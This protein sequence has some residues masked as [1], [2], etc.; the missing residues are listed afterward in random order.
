[1]MEQPLSLSWVK[2]AMVFALTGGA[3]LVIGNAAQATT[4][5]QAWH[6]GWVR[7]WGVNAVHK[8]DCLTAT[9]SCAGTAPQ[10]RDPNAYVWMPAGVCTE[11]GGT[12]IPG[13][14][15]AAHIKKIMALPAARRAA[16]KAVPMLR[17]A[18]IYNRSAAEY[19]AGAAKWIKE[20]AQ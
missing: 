18:E 15:A 16:I 4:A 2:R 19:F 5:T 11:V 20:R 3:G 8:N 1:M 12:A 7:C 9:G 10:A 13:A 14:A 6:Q 17:E